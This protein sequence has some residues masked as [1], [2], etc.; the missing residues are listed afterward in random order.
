MGFPEGR[1]L[2]K[3]VNKVTDECANRLGALMTQMSSRMDTA[4]RILEGIAS[5]E[6]RTVYKPSTSSEDTVCSNSKVSLS[7][8][9]VT[10]GT[11]GKTYASSY[12]LANNFKAEHNGEVT[13]HISCN[14]MRG[15][16]EY[17]LRQIEPINSIIFEGSMGSFHQESQ[18]KE[19]KTKNF[20]VV[21][22]AVYQIEIDLFVKPGLGVN[23]SASADATAS[24]RA[25]EETITGTKTQYYYPAN[26]APT[27][28]N[29]EGVYAISHNG[30]ENPQSVTITLFTAECDGAVV[31]RFHL[32][33]ITGTIDPYSSAISCEYWEDGQSFDKKMIFLSSHNARSFSLKVCVKKGKTYSLKIYC[34]GTQWG[35]EISDV[36]VRAVQKT[37]FPIVVAFE[38]IEEPMQT[39]IGS[40]TGYII[41]KIPDN[42]LS[43]AS[44]LIA[45]AGGGIYPDLS[46][47]SAYYDVLN[48]R[49][50]FG[51]YDSGLYTK[52]DG[53]YQAS[54]NRVIFYY[55]VVKDGK[56]C[57]FAERGSS[58]Q[59]KSLEYILNNAPCVSATLY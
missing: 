58:H 35:G 59:D 53:F 34:S 41:K 15:E 29:N 16:I 55:F 38:D 19:T 33:N 4:N 32:S 21:E 25:I 5:E 49:I 43:G 26:G 2:A 39:T 46:E 18:R 3:D 54:A 8:P 23:L 11:A 30:G 50:D 52:T 36:S 28:A 40:H 31:F 1:K 47:H 6:T 9:G 20:A 17:K 27:I 10:S 51:T 44:Y 37:S 56:L 42:I 22:G 12:I 45:V 14:Y 57:I 7:K 24:I 13:F 48:N